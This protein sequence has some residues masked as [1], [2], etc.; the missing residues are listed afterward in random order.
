MGGI[1]SGGWHEPGGPIF[2]PDGLM[3]FAQGS[4]SLSGAVEAEGFSVDLAKHPDAHDVPGQDVTLTGENVWGRD[5]T[6]VYPYN[7]ATGPYKAFGSPARAGE[8]VKGQKFCSTCVMRSRP[9]GSEPELLAW[10]VRCPWGMA[11]DEK[12]DLYV[13]DLCMEE[14]GG[15]A[16]AEDPGKV[17]LIKKAREPFGTV[18]TPDWYGFPEVAG[19]G[20][21]VWHEKHHPNRGVPPKPLLKDPPPWAGPAAWL[22]PPHSAHGKLDFCR[23]DNFGPQR[24]R[25][26]LCIFGTY[27]PLNSI[28][29]E[30]MDRG[31]AV[32]SIDLETKRCDTFMHNKHVGPATE[33]GSGGIERPVDC[34]FSHDGRSL[35]VLDFGRHPVTDKTVVAYA[36]TGV[37]W[38]ITREQ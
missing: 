32:Q 31:F 24:G 34:K 18:T 20:L 26:F 37:L 9:D 11:F 19:D 10:G 7:V 36:R 14:K 29:P 13:I 25:M 33:H 6:S 5:P 17:W 35:Y 8:V 16:V 23:S 30:H 27:Y 28:R 1:P 38:K 3:Y 2:G 12:G 22:P 15:R 4:I 21:P